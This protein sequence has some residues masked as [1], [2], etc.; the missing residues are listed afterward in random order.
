MQFDTLEP[1]GLL[2]GGTL[3]LPQHAGALD[4]L[5]RIRRTTLSRHLEALQ[6]R[7]TLVKSWSEKSEFERAA[8]APR[9]SSAQHV[10]GPFRRPHER[11]A[12][13]QSVELLSAS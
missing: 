6:A 3:V 10:W 7:D 4:R 13:S 2:A 1:R 12:R 5:T 9:P 8:A 11:H